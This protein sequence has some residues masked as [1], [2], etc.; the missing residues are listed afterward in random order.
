MVRVAE[1]AVADAIGVQMPVPVPRGSSANADRIN[2][3]TNARFWAQTHYKPGQ[4]LDPSQPADKA[5]AKVWMDIYR[6]VKAEAAGGRLVTT[7]DHPEVAQHLA[8]AAVADRAAAVH[9]EAAAKAPSPEEADKHV[10]AAAT[11][12][13]ISEQRATAAATL[14]PR[15]ASPDVA[16][17]AAAEAQAS[18][19]QARTAAEHLAQ[20]QAAAAPARVAAQPDD[21]NVVELRSKVTRLVQQ[22]FGGDFRALFQQYGQ[23]GDADK[24]A[25]TKLLADADIGNLFTRGMWADGVMKR[26]DTDRDGKISWQEFQD[27]IAPEAGVPAQMT[28]PAPQSLPPASSPAPT[29]EWTLSDFMRAGDE[30]FASSGSPAAVVAFDRNGASP[31]LQPF[32][33]YAEASPAYDL[34][35]AAPGQRWYLA[36]YGRDH[37]QEP[38]GRV[39][40]SYLGPFHTEHTDI[41]TVDRPVPAAK[42]KTS[43]KK[44]WI[45]AA[46]AG[47]LAATGIALAV[48]QNRS[49]T[50]APAARG[51]IRR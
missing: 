3:E 29:G 7:Y 41:V 18:A 44:L 21:A 14:Q 36:L 20:A 47:L 15:T 26:V 4:N 22:R 12:Q 13:Q 37:T 25:L 24:A 35:V 49:P 27:V 48:S 46:A 40:E 28:A 50:R 34:A 32:A 38:T 43:N 11:A 51:R 1:S 19:A 42:A 16:R 23:G 2:A 30:L 31:L 8:D 45:A 17:A 6:K 5:M 33:T 9:L 39:E 10:A